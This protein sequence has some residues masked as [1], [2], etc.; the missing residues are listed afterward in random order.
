MSEV[1]IGTELKLQVDIDAPLAEGEHINNFEIQIIGGGIKK[2]VKTFA[3][4]NG[5]LPEGVVYLEGTSFLVVF[6]TNE[7]GLGKV[8]CRVVVHLPDGHFLDD[9]RTE[10][11]EVDTGIEV[12]KGSI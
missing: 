9:M 11:V 3:C 7:I 8:T 10:I 5:A 6:N 1:I 4:V 12:I 2:Q